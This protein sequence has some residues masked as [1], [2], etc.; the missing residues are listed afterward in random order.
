MT[1]ISPTTKGI[2]IYKQYYNIL[3]FSYNNSIPEEITNLLAKKCAKITVNQVMDAM[4][5][6]YD[7]FNG[8]NYEF[9][10]AVKETIEGI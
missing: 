3:L 5:K 1:P 2:D 6:D 7:A 10:K 9:W 4:A 8:E